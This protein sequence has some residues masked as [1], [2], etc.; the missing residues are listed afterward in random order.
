MSS[1]T[2]DLEV[3]DGGQRSPNSCDV[4]LSLK[5]LSVWAQSGSPPGLDHLGPKMRLFQRDPSAQREKE[6]L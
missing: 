4:Q 3:V 5:T 1:G 6:I 2:G